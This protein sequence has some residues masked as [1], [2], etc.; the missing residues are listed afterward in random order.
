[1]LTPTVFGESRWN[2]CASTDLTLAI[3][4]CLH[5]CSLFVG[6]VSTHEVLFDLSYGPDDFTTKITSESFVFELERFEL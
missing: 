3:G 2:P 4:N 5:S 1:M 6:E